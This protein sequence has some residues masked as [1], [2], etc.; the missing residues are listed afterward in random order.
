MIL[1]LILSRYP[2]INIESM[3]NIIFI[4]TKILI[5]LIKIILLIFFTLT[6]LSYVSTAKA[7]QISLTLSPTQ[8]ELII[9]PNQ[10]ITQKY[11]LR[12]V[13]DPTNLSINVLSIEPKNDGGV[14]LRNELNG[15]IRFNLD[16]SG[17]SLGQS[18]FL[19]NKENKTIH[20]SIRSSEGSP[21]GDYYYAL[22]VQTDPPPIQEGK[23]SA[24]AKIT[25]GS[26]LLIT[27]NEDGLLEIKPKIS[28]FDTLSGFI[29][30]GTKIYDSSQT[31]PIVLT[32][33]NDG[34]N[35]IKAQG[36]IQIQGLLKNN[37]YLI[38]S[39][40]ILAQS[41]KLIKAVNNK[42]STVDTSLILGGLYIG[43][44]KAST[45]LNF[46]DG[47]PTLSASTSFFVFPF[48]FFAGFV[49][50]LSVSTL[51]YLKIKK[52]RED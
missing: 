26:N 38:N 14:I 20:L 32:V 39:Q 44:Y 9:K 52:N 10:I 6:Y 27:V 24:R 48:K 23:A 13:G 22:I 15:P 11:F 34:I 16:D 3:K 30:N 47:T 49:I 21:I 7:Q 43:K 8:T 41:Q 1:L 31:I 45:S 42:Q 36:K 51:I 4:K 29:L 40:N 2:D 46:G 25:L 18:F 37:T 12:N 5:P 50:T 35:L 19:K 17:L 33:G 28:I